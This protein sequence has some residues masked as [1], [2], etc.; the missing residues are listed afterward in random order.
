MAEEGADI[1]AGHAVSDQD[2]EIRDIHVLQGEG[3][4][5]VGSFDADAEVEVLIRDGMI[6]C[7]NFF[8]SD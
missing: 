5:A 6:S 4:E 2:E 1:R 3:G 7:A 8:M